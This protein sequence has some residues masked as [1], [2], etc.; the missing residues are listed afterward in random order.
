[1]SLFSIAN[2]RL[3]LLPEAV[4]TQNRCP[5]P[6]P[7]TVDPNR[8]P[9]LLPETVDQTVASNR[10]PNPWTEFLKEFNFLRFLKKNPKINFYKEN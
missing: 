5:K 6:L 7:E 9:K 8:C 4:G 3:K 10:C 1:M 2:S